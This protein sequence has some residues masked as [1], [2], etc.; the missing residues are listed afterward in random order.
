MR[1]LLF[2]GAMGCRSSGKI[3]VEQ[4]D[5]DAVEDADGDGYSG[6]E[7]CD[8]SDPQTYLGATE[9]CDGIDNNCDGTVDDGVQQSFYV[10]QDGDGF[11]DSDQ[12]VMA[13]ESVD[14]LVPNGN[15]CND[16]DASIYPGA[17]E[18]C[19]DVDNN[20]SGTIDDGDAQTYYADQDGDGFG[21]A[22]Q[23]ELFCAPVEG[24]VTNSSDCNDNDASI[25]PDATEVCDDVDNN[26]NSQIDEDIGT[27][28]YPDADDDGYGDENEAAVYSC[29]LLDNHATNRLDCNDFDSEINP[30]AQELCDYIDNNCNGIV[31][32]SAVAGNTWYYDGDSDGYGDSNNSIDSCSQPGGYVANGGD[33]DDGNNS[34]SPN[35]PEL[36]DGIDNDCSG[37]IDDQAVNASTWYLDNDS[38]GYGDGG[39]ALDSCDQPVGYVE[40]D[41]D[42]DD[43]RA[44]AYPGADE[45]CNELDDDCDG[46]IDEADAVTT[47][48]WYYDGDGDGFGDPDTS[49]T[50]CE[51]PLGYVDDDQDCDDGDT[52][53]NPD[54]V[55]ICDTLDNNCD[56]TIDEGHT[57]S[58]ALC[59]GTS[60]QDILS[61]T[62]STTDGVYWIDPD[63]NGSHEAYCDM[64]TNGGGWTLILKTS[65][66]AYV[67]LYYT[68]ALWTN[69]TLLNETSLDTSTSSNSKLESFI[70]MPLNE[71][72][73][74]FPT[75]NH[76]IYAY[77]GTNQTAKDLFSGG[78]LQIGSGFNG[79]MH[80][81]WNYQ[82]NC[83]YFGI[84]TPFAI[85]A[86]FGFSANQE[87]NCNSNDT[88]VGFGLEPTWSDPDKSLSSG[89]M[90]TWTGCSQ[91]N[92]SWSGFPGIL[93]A[94]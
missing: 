23:S 42:C 83:P 51:E 45:T 1:I 93:W 17:P 69:N 79:Q 46:D 2:L 20:C 81:G 62:G 29:D 5:V 37:V 67:S 48:N 74:C 82:S 60:C 12:E 35:M 36:C 7:D 18:I 56:G 16:D 92:Y 14:N 33:C 65:G 87:N 63:G 15:D 73:G 53:I 52:T 64:N 22:E 39:E 32:D 72:Y 27:E 3:F 30:D 49:I 75:Y 47:I 61:Q 54:S 41:N 57:G 10:D 78:S 91:S 58:D 24:W 43:T 59:P 94:R 76:C 21:D 9:V 66:D 25:S 85:R 86:R 38:D 89:H 6:E 19:D 80:S 26:C 84:N 28:Q 71:L 70:T 4:Q 55:E 31:D 77:T 34:I 68:D 40:D 13:C 11:G 50:A 88:A 8:D 90:C 44:E